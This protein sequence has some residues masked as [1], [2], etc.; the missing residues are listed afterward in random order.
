MTVPWAIYVRTDVLTGDRPALARLLTHELVHVRQW[1]ELGP[2][3]FIGEYL[4][5]YV[6]ARRR[7][8]DHQQAYLAIPLEEEARSISGH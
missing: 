5:G 8:L 4:R 1:A 7:G 3:R 2:L 6:T